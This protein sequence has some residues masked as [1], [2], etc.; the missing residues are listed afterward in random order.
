M[1]AHFGIKDLHYI[2]RMCSLFRKYF[3]RGSTIQMNYLCDYRHH[4]CNG[5]YSKM[6]ICSDPLIVN[7]EIPA[8]N[9]AVSL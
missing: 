8:A 6:C 4:L 5:Y 7:R 2:I 3:I 1:L 9:R